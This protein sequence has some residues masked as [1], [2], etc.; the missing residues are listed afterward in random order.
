MGRVR[1]L[2][3]LWIAKGGRL[4]LRILRRNA[5]YFPGYVALKLCPDFLGRVGKPKKIIAVTGTNGK[6]TVSNLLNDVLTQNGYRVL[7]NQLGSNVAAGIATSLLMG[8]GLFGKAKYETA[9]FEVDERSSKRIYPYVKPD[10]LVITNLFRDS[11]MRN[12]HPQYIAGIIEAAVPETTK[13]VLNAD[14]LISS[15]VSPNNPRVYFGLDR[16]KTD[17]T[18]CINLVNDM[19]ICPEC[20]GELVYD[21]RRYHHIGKAHCRDCG[22]KSPE[23]DYLG[24]D[25]DMDA[26]TM[27]VAD[28]DGRMQLDLLSDSIFNIY[29]MVTVIA[30]LREFGLSHDE[31]KTGFDKTK[32]VET[33]YN[34]QQAGDVKVVMQMSKDRN[35]LACSRAFDYISGQPGDK[36]IIMMMNNLS[37]DQRWSENVAW[38]YD[39][40]FEFLNKDNITRIVATGPR[41][42]D[43][44]L[45]LLMAGVPE[46]KLRCTLHEL[47]APE[48][49][50]YKT[51]SS[52]CLFYGT[53]AMNLVY[54][55]QGRI[56]KLAQEAAER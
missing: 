55:V 41:A 51:G 45:R 56:K 13:L 44:Y 6:T 29:N 1:F 39:C 36:E 32:I 53:D 20:S 11:I 12:A 30:A 10:V 5:T 25:I 31:I 48:L 52:I 21:Y 26:M 54:K 16:M 37:D 40:D 2:L 33:R 18:E 49:L 50:E 22:F 9:V 14:D 7:N 46:D 24:T 19:Q 8:C 34:V 43:Y 4:A 27:T 42:R 23:S 47:D 35:A 17:V 15:G 3:A 38:L 28:R